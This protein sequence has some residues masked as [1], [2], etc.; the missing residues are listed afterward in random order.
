MPRAEGRRGRRRA[1]PC[2]AV[3]AL[4]VLVHWQVYTIPYLYT[5]IPGIQHNRVVRDLDVFASRMLGPRGLVARPLS[6]L[7]YALGWALHGDRPWAFHLTNVAIHGVNTVLV[8]LL[9]DG[10]FRAPLVASLVFALHPLATACVSQVFGRNYS[11]ASTFMLLGLLLH[12]RWRRDGTLGRG[13][14]ACLAVLGTLAVLSKQTLIVFPLVVL[15]WEVRATRWAALASKRAALLAAAFVAVAAGLVRFYALP[16]SATSPISPASFALSQ[17]G[18]AAPIARLYVWPYSTAFVHDL[19]FYDDV[20]HPEVAIGALLVGTLAAGAW[21]WRAQPAGWLLGALLICLLP[22]NSVLPKNEVVRE[23]RLY[24]SLAFF[25]LLVAEAV[26]AAAAWMA[27]RPGGPRA[28][29]LPYAAAAAYLAAYAHAD[30]RQ[31]RIYQSETA[32]WEQVLA[33]YPHSADAMN[34]LGLQHL[35]RGHLATARRYFEMAADAAPDVYVYRENLA[36][37]CAALHEPDVAE[38]YA[39]EAEEIRQRYGARTMSL[40]HR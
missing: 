20:W 33:R 39:V 40:H 17:L 34:N 1:V 36:R 21:R 28:A 11:L 31:D 30:V 3:V 8:F 5:E 13:Q 16:L 7:S 22:T 23:W 15:W 37:V 38:R 12:L 4:S 24:P 27:R 35:R 9:A 29:W 18:N 10:F 2:A 14:V 6:V 32:A 25:A 19:W 26:A